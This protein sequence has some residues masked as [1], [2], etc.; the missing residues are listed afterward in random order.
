[1]GRAEILMIVSFRRSVT[2]ATTLILARMFGDSLDFWL[3]VQR[4][5]DLGEAVHSPG[6]TLAD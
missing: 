6:A 4:R 2:V 1:L 3:N 5:T